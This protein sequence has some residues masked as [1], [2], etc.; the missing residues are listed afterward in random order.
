MFAISIKFAFLE[1]GITF[2]LF[3]NLE[4]AKRRNC[5][6]FLFNF[7][8]LNFLFLTRLEFK[9]LICDIQYFIKQP[10]NHSYF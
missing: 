2:I 7:Y 1:I 5:F 4:R 10:Y 6:L 9:N 8:I 3:S